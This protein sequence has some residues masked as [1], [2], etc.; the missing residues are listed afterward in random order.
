M[1]QLLGFPPS[2]EQWDAIAGP[3]TPPTLVLAGAGS[4]KTT[5]MAA[6]VAWLV[7]VGQV[8]PAQILGLTFMNK[9]A[10]ELA[11][12]IRSMLDRLDVTDAGVDEPAVMTYDAFAADL[13]SQWGLLSGVETGLTLADP[14]D[15]AVL[16][17]R[18]ITE[19]D[20]PLEDIGSVSVPTVAKRLLNLDGQLAEHLVEPEQLRA[21]DRALAAALPG[22]PV[23]AATIGRVALRRAVAAGV[24]STLRT[25]RR[26]RG[27]TSFA[28]RTRD[29]VAAAGHPRVREALREQYRV[30]LLDEYQD[31]SVAQRHLLVALFADGHPVLAVGDPLQAIYG[32]RGA[33]VANI[34]R[35]ID[36]FGGVGRVLPLT[37]NR[38]SDRRILTTANAV[39]DDLRSQHR[40][41][42]P[43][44]PG[45]ETAG[46]VT[47]AL[48]E[49]VA[50]ELSWLIDQVREQLGE[51]EPGEIA[52][53]CRRNADVRRVAI[54]LRAAGVPVAVG[55]VATV[56]QLPECLDVVNMLRVCDSP[57]ANAALVHV[58]TGP[59]WRIGPADL[60][61]LGERAAQLAP[62]L[63]PTSSEDLAED[64]RRAVAPTDPADRPSLLAAV[65]DPG[66]L[67]GRQA[68]QR[69]AEFIAD[70]D[71]IRSAVAAGIDE[72]V[73]RII[74]VTGLA[75]EVRLG[76]DSAS[77][78]QSLRVLY[79]VIGEYRRHHGD[80]SVR[81][82]LRWLDVAVEMDALP[83]AAL[84]IGP[85][86]VHVSTVHRAKGLEWDVVFVPGL[87]EGVFPDAKA[88]G[89]WTTHWDT[90]PTPLRGDRESMP[91]WRSWM[92]AATG[93]QLD[94]D[95]LAVDIKALSADNAEHARW[96]EDRLGYV[97]LTRARRRMLL[98]GYWWGDSRHPRGP[99]SLLRRVVA[100]DG[101][102][103]GPW[104]E[105]SEHASN[106]IRAGGDL[107][108]P[109][110]AELV[111]VP[112]LTDRVGRDGPGS[113]TGIADR[114][115]SDIPRLTVA[116]SAALAALDA[117]I[118]SVVGRA[119][120]ESGPVTEVAVPPDLTVSQVQRALADPAGFAADLLRPMPS[121]RRNSAQRG[122][123]F[124]EWVARRSDQLSLLPEWEGAPDADLAEDPDFDALVAAFLATPYAGRH[125]LVTETPV[126]VTLGGLV[127]RGV[128]DAV[129]VD[130]AGRHEIV[131]WKT[132][133]QQTA[134]PVQLA[135]YR[136]AWARTQGLDPDTVSAVFVYVRT[137][138]VVRPTLLGEQDLAVLLSP[139]GTGSRP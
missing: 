27:L 63:A 87:T 50:D 85:D 41:T 20:L 8:A 66:P 64:I 105:Q 104:C 30:V 29:A 117:D 118:A 95:R 44:A 9:A 114:N 47:A 124:H 133:R 130:E 18:Q 67:V 121:V 65:A 82:F 28:D 24:V 7:A 86:A 93:G 101:V 32:W 79:D 52:V 107:P 128:V 56:L 126:A 135:V 122:T 137:G 123:R 115:S 59:R 57:L 38:R 90:L 81:G 21:H 129:Y 54:A 70:L 89:L 99:S 53:L 113:S 39:A 132:H 31:T 69:L 19:L 98:S 6:R 139:S 111:A 112:E 25:D 16:T 15:L 91:T 34:D 96:E 127:V 125:P 109:P 35:F 51:T 61:A 72:A 77:R 58:L 103:R 45:R 116:E 75:V 131:D 48:F 4:G 2:D 78:M 134:D 136:L 40:R 5:I 71:E 94:A 43:L 14:T 84:P 60:A 22:R 138:E 26:S 42:R 1:A 49:T 76:A 17:H 100:A 119:R 46:Q 62:G 83:E 80:P 97:A 3:L 73:A 120:E 68:G 13:L 102:D 36:H 12:R 88:R 33:S 55:S 106:P 108:W 23:A 11:E 37:V 10:G 92:W 74:D 110:P